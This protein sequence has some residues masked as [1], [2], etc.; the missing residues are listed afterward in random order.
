MLKQTTKGK[1][2]AVDGPNGVGKTTI[3]SEITKQLKKKL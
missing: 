2:I 1:L 3:I